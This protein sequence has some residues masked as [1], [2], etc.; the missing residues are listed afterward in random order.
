MEINMEIIF[1]FETGKILSL[2]Q[3][4]VRQNSHVS[5]VTLLL[6]YVI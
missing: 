2:L 1:K 3:Q 5:T 6:S 4:Y